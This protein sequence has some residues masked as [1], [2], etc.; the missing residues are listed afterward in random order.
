[1]I[2]NAASPAGAESSWIR[3]SVS[4][5]F[6]TPESDLYLALGHIHSSGANQH[7]LRRQEQ[8]V[9]ETSMAED[10]LARLDPNAQEREIPNSAHSGAIFS[11]SSGRA[12]NRPMRSFDRCIRRRDDP[13]RACGAVRAVP[14]ERTGPHKRHS[15]N[16]ARK[17]L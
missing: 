6:C 1:M 14:A 13:R 16:Q 10:T 5:Y 11:P 3:V 2:G 7:E 12:T 4:V 9:V 15:V 8:H 17:P